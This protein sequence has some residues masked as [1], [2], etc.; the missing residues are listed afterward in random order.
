MK[1]QQQHI[2]DTLTAKGIT[3][4][5]VDV[6]ASQLIKEVLR[7]ES[8]RQLTLPQIWRGKECLGGHEEFENALEGDYL[9]QFLLI[10]S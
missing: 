4:V 2:F 7:E 9:N 10:C 6:A 3:Y 8:P 5:P 1:R